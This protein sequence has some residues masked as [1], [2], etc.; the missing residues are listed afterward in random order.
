MPRTTTGK[1]IKYLLDE[2]RQGDDL[3]FAIEVASALVDN[4]VSCA[5]GNSI[6]FGTN[7]VELME[8]MLAAHFYKSTMPTY[9]EKKTGDAMGKFW[10]ADDLEGLRG[11]RHGQNAIAFDKSGCLRS[12]A[13]GIV[14]DLQWLGKSYPDALSYEDRN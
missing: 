7:E 14:I 1:V 11:T 9:R 4:V 5:S 10:G 2:Y 13:S 6:T 3:G 8:R 12:Y